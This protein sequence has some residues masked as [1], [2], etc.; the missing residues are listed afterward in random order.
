[1]SVVRAPVARFLALPAEVVGQRELLLTWEGAL[2]PEV[3]AIN[4]RPENTGTYELLFD[5]QVREFDQLDWQQLAVAEGT[6]TSGQFLA[7]CANSRYEFRVRARAEQTPGGASPNQRYLGVWSAPVTVQFVGD[8][9]PPPEPDEP[10]EDDADPPERENMIFLP[11][12]GAL[13]C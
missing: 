8:S 7:P 12:L 3:V 9:N 5:V 10:G 1:V 13:G 6:E 4:E 2:P 11:L